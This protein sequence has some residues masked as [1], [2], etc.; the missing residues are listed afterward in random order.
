[1]CFVGVRRK[2]QLGRKPRGSK[3]LGA[4]ALTWLENSSCSPW[5]VYLKSVAAIVKKHSAC[6]YK[7]GCLFPTIA[8]AISP[9][10]LKHQRVALPLTSTSWSMTHILLSSCPEA[11]AAERRRWRRFPRLSCILSGLIL[12]LHLYVFGPE[13]LH[14]GDMSWNLFTW[15]ACDMASA[16]RTRNGAPSTTFERT[17]PRTGYRS[18]TCVREKKRRV[19]THERED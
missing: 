2:R 13:A 16:R 7:N 9:Y 6:T 19:P 14:E 15:Q 1:M 11:S 5:W 12:T 10:K 3:N 17:P 18:V 4:K 8:G